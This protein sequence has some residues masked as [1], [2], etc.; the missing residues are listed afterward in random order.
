MS[1]G[2]PMSQYDKSLLQRITMYALPGTNPHYK[3]LLQYSILQSIIPVL[4]RST[5]FFLRTKKY[6]CVLQRTPVLLGTIRCYSS[7]FS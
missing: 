1:Y 3:V 4:L 7:T 2:E 5:K 6:Y